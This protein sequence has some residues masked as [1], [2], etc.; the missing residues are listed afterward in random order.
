MGKKQTKEIE[1]ALE[2][3]SSRI[4]Y[5][6][7]GTAFRLQR[8]YFKE[9]HLETLVVEAGYTK[10]SVESG[11]DSTMHNVYTEFIAKVDDSAKDARTFLMIK[12]VEVLSDGGEDTDLIKG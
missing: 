7:G 3:S 2:L 6:V 12:R 11:L 10:P 5:L 9:H 8:Q 4:V 1:F